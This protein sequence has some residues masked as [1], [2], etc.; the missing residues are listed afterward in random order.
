MYQMLE[1]QTGVVAAG[2]EGVELEDW[3][4]VDIAELLE[5]WAGRVFA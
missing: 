2:C 4:S 3:K 5:V 1:V